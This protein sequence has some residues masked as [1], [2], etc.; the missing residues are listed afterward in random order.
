MGTRFRLNRTGRDGNVTVF[1]PPTV[2]TCKNLIDT[3]K[4]HHETKLGCIH[5][6]KNWRQKVLAAQLKPSTCGSVHNHK[7]L[8]V[9]NIVFAMQ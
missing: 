1:M 3:Y 8:T 6:Y 2:D 5:G 4:F 9:S 7:P